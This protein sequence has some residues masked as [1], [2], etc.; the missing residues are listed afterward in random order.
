MSMDTRVKLPNPE[1]EWGYTEVQI[2][3]ICSV[4]EDFRKWMYGQTMA[5]CE[6]RKYNYDTQE[7]EESCGGVAHGMIVYPWDLVRY[8]ECRPVVD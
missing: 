8:I 1:C 3:Q 7:Y 2:E 4:P 6:G 5:L